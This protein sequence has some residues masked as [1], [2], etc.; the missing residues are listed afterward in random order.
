MVT[1]TQSSVLYFGVRIMMPLMSV[2][3][4]GANWAFALAANEIGA[5]PAYSN[6]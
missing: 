2:I 3:A 6:R 5:M 4:L 1:F